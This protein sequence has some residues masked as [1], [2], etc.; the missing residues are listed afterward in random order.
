MM[1]LRW[2]GAGFDVLHPKN[3]IQVHGHSDFFLQRFAS[4][5]MALTA[6]ITLKAC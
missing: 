4:R 3:G 5:M 2:S 6:T 1:N